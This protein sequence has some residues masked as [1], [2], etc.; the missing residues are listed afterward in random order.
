[1]IVK[2]SK[3][4]HHAGKGSRF[5]PIGAVEKYRSEAESNTETVITRFSPSNVNLHKPFLKIMENAGRIPWPKM[6]QNLRASCETEWLDSGL[7]AHVVTS[8]MGHSVKVQNNS[9][10]Q[11]DDHHS[12]RF[13]EAVA[14]CGHF[15]CRTFPM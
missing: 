6:F 5:L 15:L 14:N 9:H 7:P 12:Q 8:W 2:S 10:A 3:T 13:N 1:M 11:V 4:A